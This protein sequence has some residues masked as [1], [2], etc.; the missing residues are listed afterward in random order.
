[1]T[2]WPLHAILG[3]AISCAF[4]PAAYTQQSGPRI[5]YV[6]PAGVRQGMQLDVTVGGKLLDGTISAQVSGSG[7]QTFV[8]GHIKPK[9][10]PTP[11]IAETVTIHVTVASDAA[12]GQ[13]ELRL[14]SPAGLTNPLVF[15]VGSL[16]EFEEKPS[17][18]GTGPAETA[19]TLPAILHGQILPGEADRFRFTARKGERL[20]FAA[21]AR[22]LIPYLPDAVPGWFQAVLALYDA[23]GEEVAYADSFRFNADPVL[24]YEVPKD[25]PYVLEIRD[26]IYRGREDFVYRITAG[27]SPFITSVFPMGGKAGAA[28]NVELKGWNLPATKLTMDAQD[29]P[30]G[31][32][33]LFVSRRKVTLSED[34]LA[35]SELVSRMELISNRV[36]FAIDTLP[37]L[38]EKEPNDT[39]AAAQQVVLPVIVNGRI[40][41][42]GDW[43]VF[44]F[45]GRK[46]DEIVVEVHARR[47]GS[48]LDSVL[49][50]TDAAGRQLAFN[51]DHEDKAAGLE[52]HHADS[53]LRTALPADGTYFVYLGDVQ[54]RGGSDYGYRLRISPPQNDFEL[55]LVPSA[56]N[57]RGG[58]TV[59]LTV[60]ALRRD[61]FSGEI[62]LALKDGPPKMTLAGA[63]VP[64]GEDQ[65]RLTLTAPPTLPKGPVGLRLEGRATIRGRTV[66]R[67]VVPTE[68]MMQAF[69]YR[70]LVPVKELKMAQSE[71]AIGRTVATLLSATPVKI[72]AGGSMQIQL[73]VPA[74]SSAGDLHFELDEPPDGVAIQSQTARAEG[75]QIVLH[76]DAEK[77]KPGLQGNLIVSAFARAPRERG[78]KSAQTTSRRTPLGILPAIAFEIVEPSTSETTS[79]PAGSPPALPGRSP[80]R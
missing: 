5:G 4:V 80:A 78:K 12:P 14:E 48:P 71:R 70:H 51:D 33:P 15:Y 2:S 66:I 44:R 56:V 77:V 22:E 26:S 69:A 8:I 50:L 37:E 9:R 64:A 21:G 45:K 60:Y 23:K 32:Y 59:P 11:A 46:G 31:I 79:S 34:L 67:P 16:P 20:V 58:A 29:K 73:G 41:Q 43:D 62:T 13:R 72:P 6:Y 54:R 27:E 35:G 57:V 39:S 61:G 1:M 68:D 47:L 24:Y 38:L 65:V 55:R 7:V 18:S 30:P 42:P 17:G 53:L 28:T 52:T 63:R 40:D 25:G 76:G 10:S 3:V 36:P 49:K 75:A 19:I 74:G